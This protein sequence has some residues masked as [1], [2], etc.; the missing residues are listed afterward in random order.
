MLTKN[1]WSV[2]CTFP[3]PLLSSKKIVGVWLR[4]WFKLRHLAVPRFAFFYPFTF[5]KK[6]NG[7]VNAGKKRTSPSINTLPCFQGV[8]EFLK[9]KVKNTIQQRCESKEI[10]EHKSQSLWMSSPIVKQYWENYF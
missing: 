10:E 9:I 2:R 8:G 1:E 5:L 7:K 6:N 4:R 3:P